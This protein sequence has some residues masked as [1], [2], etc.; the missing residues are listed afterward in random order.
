MGSDTALW[1]V[2]FIALVV[3]LGGV[4]R[5]RLDVLRHQQAEL[6]R[7]VR[8]RTQQ[9]EEANRKLAQISYLEGSPTSRTGARS[10]RS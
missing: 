7:L 8:E 3:F 1:I 2:A 5:W 6:M 9:L 4:H 10:K